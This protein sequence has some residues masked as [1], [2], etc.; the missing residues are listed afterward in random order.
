MNILVEYSEM[1]WISILIF[2]FSRNKNWIFLRILKSGMNIY[3]NIQRYSKWNEY[4]CEYSFKYSKIFKMEWIFM[5]IFIWIFIVEYSEDQI[6]LIFMNIHMN[7][8]EGQIPRCSWR[9]SDARKRSNSCSCIAFGSFARATHRSNCLMLLVR[10]SL[11]N[12]SLELLER[13]FYDCQE[14]SPTSLLFRHHLFLIGIACSKSGNAILPNTWAIVQNH[15]IDFFKFVRCL[16]LER[17]HSF[18][19]LNRG[20]LLT[21][22]KE[23][24]FPSRSFV[25]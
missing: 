14:V 4:S 20:H 19:F 25:L 16:I 1:E 21:R 7:I 10:N 24:Q 22:Q 5:R 17:D 23:L 3:L 2:N 6:F 18:C 8:H 12:L 13:F 9:P 15:G 11:L